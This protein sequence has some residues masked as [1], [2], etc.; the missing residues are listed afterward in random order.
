MDSLFCFSG[1][2]ADVSKCLE[3]EVASTVP[4]SDCSSGRNSV[5][6]H[7]ATLDCSYSSPMKESCQRTTK[8]KHLISLMKENETSAHADI[9]D[10]VLFDIRDLVQELDIGLRQSIS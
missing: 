10:H 8:L 3:D 1:T 5:D 7:K 2:C 9:D 6:G 4:S